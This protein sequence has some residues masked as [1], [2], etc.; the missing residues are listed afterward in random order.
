MSVLLENSSHM[1]IRCVPMAF[2][3]DSAVMYTCTFSD[4]WM[5]YVIRLWNDIVF[6]SGFWVRNELNHPVK[7]RFSGERQYSRWKDS[8]NTGTL[9]ANSLY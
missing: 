9:G 4:L 3:A 7:R 1:I 8:L 6:T 5:A 2:R